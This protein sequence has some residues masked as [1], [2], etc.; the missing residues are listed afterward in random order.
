LCVILYTVKYAVVNQMPFS[1]G[2]QINSFVPDN[3]FDFC[4]IVYI[5]VCLLDLS[6]LIIIWFLCMSQITFTLHLLR[7]Q[8]R[9]HDAKVFFVVARV[10]PSC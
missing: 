6:Y 2:Q 4:F 10:L 8:T 5:V 9:H 1:S 7:K 3:R